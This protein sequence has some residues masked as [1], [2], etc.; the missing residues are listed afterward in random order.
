MRLAEKLDE[1]KKQNRAYVEVR[2]IPPS[3]LAILYHSCGLSLTSSA[4]PCTS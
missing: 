4:Y 3:F 1:Q 2:P